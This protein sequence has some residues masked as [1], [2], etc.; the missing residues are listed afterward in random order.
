MLFVGDFFGVK[1]WNFWSFLYM[2]FQESLSVGYLA[3][4]VADSSREFR[5]WR[6]GLF[7]TDFS[8]ELMCN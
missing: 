5:C 7:V 6:F 1:E 8:K 2:T 3:L 4:F